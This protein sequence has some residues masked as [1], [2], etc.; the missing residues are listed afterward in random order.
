VPDDPG[1]RAELLRPYEHPYREFVPAVW[2]EARTGRTALIGGA[3]LVG[4]SVATAATDFDLWAVAGTFAALVAL[5]IVL[6][7]TLEATVV[8][9]R[10]SRPWDERSELGTVCARR[11][12]AGEADPELVHPEFAVT[13]EETGQLLVWRF[14]PLAVME[15]A[16]EG[17]V[18]VPGRPRYAADVVEERPLDPDPARAAEALAETQERAAQLEAEAR[19][20]ARQGRI[21]AAQRRELE[22]ETSSTAAALQHLTGQRP[23]RRD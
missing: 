21:D 17:E 20:A 10:F 6:R 8:I 5:W 14:R 18:L 19:E 22:Q 9:W 23:A 12:H 15:V 11:P 2:R 13:V 3:A 1:S 4:G 7:V 16:R